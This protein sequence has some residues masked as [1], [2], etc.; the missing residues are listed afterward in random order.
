MSSLFKVIVGVLTGATSIGFLLFMQ[1]YTSFKVFIPLLVVWL[2]LLFIY[3][4]FLH[5]RVALK[6]SILWQGLFTAL[7]LTG[8]IVVVESAQTRLFLSALAAVVLGV[9]YA[10]AIE[11][12]ETAHH[13][14]KPFRRFAMMLWVFNAYA[15]FTF[16]FA[17]GAFFPSS[18]LFLFLT[19][20]GGIIAAA[21]ALMVWREYYHAGISTFLIWSILVAVV[22][23]ELMW[24]LHLLPFAYSVL[25][26]CMVWIWYIMQLLIRFHF[27]ERGIV[28]K[29]QRVFLITNIVLYIIVLTFFVRWV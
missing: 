2:G 7:A 19:I 28:W 21:V 20:I 6:Q 3:H 5:T 11:T 14:R 17:L 22:T 10:W 12:K 27:S 1:R 8:L 13:A 25:G 18:G 26:L 4:R 24:I 29:K 15:L 23:I 16:F 9:L